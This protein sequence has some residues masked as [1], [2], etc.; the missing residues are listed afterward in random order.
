MNASNWTLSEELCKITS[1][2]SEADALFSLGIIA[3]SSDSYLIKTDDVW[4][5]GGA[6]TYI[7]KFWVEVNEKVKG[8][9]IKACVTLDLAKGLEGVINSW[10]ERRYLLLHNKI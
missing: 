3:N 1:K 10:L 9:I 4:E 2:K 8:Y 5:R 6:E 7:Y